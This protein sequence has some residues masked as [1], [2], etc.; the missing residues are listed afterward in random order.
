LD[1]SPEEYMKILEKKAAN[2]E[3][4][5]HIAALLGGGSFKEVEALA[6]YGRIL[7]TLATLREEFIDIFET[8]EMNQ[9]IKAETLPIPVLYAF[10]DKESRKRIGKMVGRNSLTSKDI[11]RL[12][13]LVLSSESVLKLRMHM[14][15]LVAQARGVT[16][17]LRNDAAKTLLRRLAATTLEDL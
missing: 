3:A 10:Q 6:R 2:I 4:D 1:A 14:S 15:D 8:E 12:L 16:A 7:G 13:D 9:R 17:N 11:E 5:M